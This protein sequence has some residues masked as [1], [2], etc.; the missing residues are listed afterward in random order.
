MKEEKEPKRIALVESLLHSVYDADKTQAWELVSSGLDRLDDEMVGMHPSHAA[1]TAKL[2]RHRFA[3]R[4]VA[5]KLAISAAILM[6][7]LIPVLYLSESA[8]ATIQRSLDKALEDIGRRYCVTIVNQLSQGKTQTRL[9]DLYVKG[10]DQFAVHVNMSPSSLKSVW[11]GSNSEKSWFIPPV[12]PVFEGDRKNLTEWL[13][14]RGE[15]ST[16]YLHIT[17][18]L[19]GMRDLYQLNSLEDEEIVFNGR[20]V[21]CVRII[22]QLKDQS[23]QLASSSAPP[24]Q[25]DLWASRETDVAMKLVVTWNLEQEDVGR[26]TI[27]VQLAEEVELFDEFFTADGHDIEGRLKID[28]SAKRNE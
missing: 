23:N 18:A 20:T 27:T 7:I 11:H 25:I 15:V 12:G 13:N 17:T 26:K 8:A 24:D 19:E 14:Q 10:G 3:F 6:A 1:E 2:S 22:G 28:F 16:P 21:R 9:A 5:M 4:G